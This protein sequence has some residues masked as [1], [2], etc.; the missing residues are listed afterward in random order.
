[1]YEK[2]DCSHN[3]TL[4]LDLDETAY[5]VL[6]TEEFEKHGS[7][8]ESIKEYKK[9]ASSHT[10]STGIQNG[11]FY[12]FVINPEELK[13]M[14]EKVYA[15]GDDIVIFTSGLWASAVLPIVS[16]LC[17]LTSEYAT[18]F[19]SCLF[20]NPHH[21]SDK[22]GCSLLATRTLLKAYRLHGLFR[23]M[24]VLRSSAF[25]LL[26]NNAAHVGSCAE[27]TYI[28]GV[29]ATTDVDDKSFYEQVPKQMELAHST[30]RQVSPG[31]AVYYYPKEVLN[32]LL[33]L[34]EG[35]NTFQTG[36]SKY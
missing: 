6:T 11:G 4:L 16:R 29:R 27:L 34:Q 12:F 32:R 28:E 30:D 19:N 15:Q 36:L 17:G 2:K 20:L 8:Y 10:L 21:D 26:D 5:I 35:K 7:T 9:I 1:M 18:K 24:E 13:K 23:S 3:T 25:V 31:S 14:I 22:L 33:Q